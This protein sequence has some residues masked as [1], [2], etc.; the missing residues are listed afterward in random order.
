MWAALY[1]LANFQS[2]D[3]DLDEGYRP[4]R[5]KPLTLWQKGFQAVHPP[6]LAFLR[7][8][9]RRQV[10][11]F[12]RH[13][14]LK[15]KD[16][17]ELGFG[18][19]DGS[20]SDGNIV[21]DTK[22][23]K[24]PDASR[25]GSKRKRGDPVATDSVGMSG[26]VENPFIFTSSSVHEDEEQDDKFFFVLMFLW[27]GSVREFLERHFIELPKAADLIEEKLATPGPSKLWLKSMKNK[28]IGGDVSKMV[29]DIQHFKIT[30]KISRNTWTEGGN[31]KSARY[32]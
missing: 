12:Y 5:P 26:D 1:C 16:R 30:G 32:T 24:T 7:E 10:F 8:V 25:R 6:E 20:I 3:A 21:A 15:P 22:V 27:G 4:G 11:P 17:S 2:K 18:E 23:M 9:T 14:L 19:L 28:N 29:H 13:A 31:K